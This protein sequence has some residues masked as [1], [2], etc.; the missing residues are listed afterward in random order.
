MVREMRSWAEFEEDP[1]DRRG[2]VIDLELIQV[3]RRD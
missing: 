2:P 1:F 3:R